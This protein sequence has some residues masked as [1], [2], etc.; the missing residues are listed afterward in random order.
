MK[1][2][3][4]FLTPV[5]SSVLPFTLI[6]DLTRVRDVAQLKQKLSRK[7]YTPPDFIMIVYGRKPT[8][9]QENCSRT[10]P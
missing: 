4:K 2:Q 1:K 9:T 3:I 10:K 8:P 6:V 5:N 7:F